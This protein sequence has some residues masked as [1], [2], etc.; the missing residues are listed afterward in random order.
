[1]IATNSLV[2]DNFLVTKV[3]TSNN[4]TQ[5]L[6]AIQIVHNVEHK[7]LIKTHSTNVCPHYMVKQF[8]QEPMGRDLNVLQDLVKYYQGIHTKFQDINNATAYIQG[9]QM[10]TKNRLQLHLQSKFQNNEP[11]DRLPHLC[12]SIM[13]IL[14]TRLLNCNTWKQH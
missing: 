5:V 11:V 12:Q 6:K 7:Y 2:T 14:M 8:E 9:V 4:N 10:S 3:V 13:A 1:M